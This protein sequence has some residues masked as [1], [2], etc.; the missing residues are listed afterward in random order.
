M[1]VNQA[2]RDLRAKLILERKLLR[3]LN[4]FMRRVARAMTKKY[5]E[6]GT[7]IDAL[8]FLP[9]LEEILFK[10]YQKVNKEF[11]DR[12]TENLPEEIEATKEERKIIDEALLLFSIAQSGTQSKIIIETIQ[13]D[14]I[15]AFQEANDF[16]EEQKAFR[17]LEIAIVAATNLLKR[18][19]GR[20]STIAAY[21]TQVMAETAKGTEVQV[22]SR[23]DPSVVSGTNRKSGVKKEWVTMGDEVVRTDHIIAD[24]DV[25]DINEPFIVGGE[26]MMWPAD[27]SR[28]ASIGNTINCRCAAVYDEETVYSERIESATLLESIQESL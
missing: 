4:S 6:T 20:N 5:A 1:A 7:V 26:E 17:P 8:I 22:L 23:Q 28:G 12:I 24:G 25:A 2:R 27:M 19:T 13:K 16:L 9:E 10:H 11:D 3:Q 14:I 18:I 15:K 21:E